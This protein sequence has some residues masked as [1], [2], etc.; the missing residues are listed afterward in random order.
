MTGW[1]SAQVMS[2]P[3][4]S[5]TNDLTGKL[6]CHVL[7]HVRSAHHYLSQKGADLDFFCMDAAKLSP[8]L[9][10]SSFARIEVGRLS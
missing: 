1:D 8:L 3:C 6:Y 9:S 10:K 5:A 2:T 7:S 4:G